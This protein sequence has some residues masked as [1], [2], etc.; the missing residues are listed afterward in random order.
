MPGRRLEDRRDRDGAEHQEGGEDAERE[1]EIADPVDDEG[2]ERRGVGRGLVVP[3]A[4]QQVGSEADALPAEEHLDEIVRRHQHQHREGEERQIGEEAGLA[5]VLRHIAPGVEVDERR[6]G[7]HHH[8]HHRGQSVDAQR[9]VDLHRGGMDPGRGPG[10]AGCARCRRRSR[11]RS[12][13]TSAMP[14]NSAPVVIS[15][16]AKLPIMRLPSPATI[17]ASK[18]QEDDEL[19]GHAGA[20]PLTP[21][22]GGCR[23][24]RSCRGRG[25]R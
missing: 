2:L 25:S 9:P 12:A 22:S 16:A 14:T 10:R 3:E 20:A 19:D 4:D 5:V 15:L 13:R 23:R 7:R 17:A 18:R 21:S 1:A 8:Q 24:P 6:D 11:G